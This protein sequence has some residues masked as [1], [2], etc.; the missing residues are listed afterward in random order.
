MRARGAPPPSRPR[1]KLTPLR[2]VPQGTPRSQGIHAGDTRRGAAS[3]HLSLR[4]P[5]TSK[6]F[7][8]LSAAV[9]R[10]VLQTSALTAGTPVAVAT[11]TR[12]ASST[13]SRAPPSE[14]LPFP[15]TSSSERT[16]LG[17]ARFCPRSASR[18]PPGEPRL[19]AS[20]PPLRSRQLVVAIASSCALA[21]QCCRGGGPRQ[22]AYKSGDRR[23]R[24]VRAR[25]C[26]TT[27]DS[28]SSQHLG[29]RPRPMPQPE[30]FSAYR[31][32]RRE[33]RGY[34]FSAR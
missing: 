27:S 26:C 1:R 28:G 14:R 34:R 13:C 4:A 8:A 30:A 20:V 12:S 3:L 7:G 23:S 33:R 6:D 19:V 9:T 25:R 17:D 2:L 10:D 15:A 21:Y 5:P 32:R 31:A 24:S 18:R 29:R 16:A 22:R 11:T